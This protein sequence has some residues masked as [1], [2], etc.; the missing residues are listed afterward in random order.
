MKKEVQCK[1]CGKQFVKYSYEKIARCEECR[2]IN[3]MRAP[4]LSVQCAKAKT[5]ART[6]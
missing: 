4:G 3:R 5:L 1:Q 6:S 2:R